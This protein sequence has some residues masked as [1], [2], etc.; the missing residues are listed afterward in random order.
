MN[1]TICTTLSRRRA[2]QQYLSAIIGA[3]GRAQW[4]TPETR[5][6]IQNQKNAL[7]SSSI[8]IRTPTWIDDNHLT[9]NK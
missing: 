7:P 2:Q 4:R 8:V 3:T 1:E 5:N 6:K 9:S